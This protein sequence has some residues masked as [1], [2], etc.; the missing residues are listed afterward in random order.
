MRPQQLL[1]TVILMLIFSM[2]IHAQHELYRGENKQRM[3]EFAD[4]F[5]REQNKQYLQSQALA[6]QNGIKLQDQIGDK[7]ITLQ[8]INSLGEALYLGI[9]SNRRS[10][11]I[12]QTDQLYSTGGLGLSLTGKSDTLA[13][14]LALW[15]GG[16]AMSTHQEFGGR[17]KSQESV[18]T[19]D[20]HATHV[21]G[22][23]IASGVIAS[24]RGMAF[25]ADLKVW[26]Y[27]NDNSEISAASPN[28]LISNH[29]YG[30]QAG[31]VYDSTKNKWQ[32]WGNDAIS[33][34]EDYK[35]GYYD[36]NAQA[37]DK[38]AFN[39]PY[40]LITKSAGNSRSENG[41]DFTKGEYYYLKNTKDSSNII[42][43]KNDA[44]DIIST[45]G[46]AKNILT[47]GA[48]ESIQQTPNLASDL[49]VSNFTSWGPTDDG[50]IKPDIMGVGTDIL[51]T[52]NT[53]KSLKVCEA[54]LSSV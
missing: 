22:T 31:W 43:S 4:D 40:Y 47:V 39:A 30:Y 18:L 49:R 48:I 32:W 24:A 44:Y 52:S 20:L 6:K 37:L 10:A 3:Q 8:Q 11:Q 45:T 21:A 7:K 19:S 23:M 1:N 16:G 15:D 14:K 13:G 27:N 36:S 50:R 5:S 9:E 54:R 34:L 12:T 35:F 17:I 2:S 42:R 26:D 51:S 33:T 41:P 46:T 38:I 28:L 29:S 53:S 25:G